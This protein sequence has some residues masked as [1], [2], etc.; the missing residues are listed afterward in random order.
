[1][2]IIALTQEEFRELQQQIGEIRE[3]LNSTKPENVVYDNSDVM[4]LLEVSARTLCTWLVEWHH[5]IFKGR[6]QN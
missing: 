2:N 6:C 1:M 5:Q 3:S 4:R